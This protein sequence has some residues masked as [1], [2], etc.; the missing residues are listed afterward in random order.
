M[1][2]TAFRRP[3][4]SKT[5]VVTL[6]AEV[7]EQAGDALEHMRRAT[8][9]PKWAILEHLLKHAELTED[10]IPVGWP[11]AANTQEELPIRRAG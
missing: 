6:F 3:R 1:T 11:D 5:D 8:G 10:G 9:A 2:T 4:G 7:D